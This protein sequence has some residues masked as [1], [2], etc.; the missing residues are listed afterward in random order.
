MPNLPLSSES[1]TATWLTRHCA[2]CLPQG[3]PCWQ[4]HARAHVGSRVS[5]QDEPR[6]WN[7]TL[8]LQ[9]DGNDRRPS[10]TDSLKTPSYLTRPSLGRDLGTGRLRPPIHTHIFFSY[11]VYLLDQ[12]RNWRPDKQVSQQNDQATHGQGLTGRDWGLHPL[13]V[14]LLPTGLILV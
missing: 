10:P 2:S 6:L 13:L 9:R 7:R 12:G 14:S 5:L 1:L 11:H 4:D 8:R 3:R